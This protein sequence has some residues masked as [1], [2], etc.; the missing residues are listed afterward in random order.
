MST[1][2]QGKARPATSGNKVTDRAKAPAQTGPGEVDQ[3]S[4]AR[5]PESRPSAPVSGRADQGSTKGRRP[6]WVSDRLSELSSEVAALHAEI[7][8]LPSS[9]VINQQGARECIAQ[10]AGRDIVTVNNYLNQSSINITQIAD[11]RD[12]VDAVGSINADVLRAQ[13]AGFV[14][15]PITRNVDK[16]LAAAQEAVTAQNIN[17][18]R[19]QQALHQAR[20]QLETCAAEVVANAK[21]ELVDAEEAARLQSREPHIARNHVQRARGWLGIFAGIARIILAIEYVVKFAPLLAMLL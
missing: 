12:L 9:T 10:I 13:K 18:T 14:S 8:K 3:V 7:E 16:A 1:G 15:E 6:I 4:G 5:G 17:T 19:F 21:N 20:R 11:W 2:Q